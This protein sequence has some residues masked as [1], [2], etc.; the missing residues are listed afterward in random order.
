M[1]QSLLRAFLFS[2]AGKFLLP[3]LKQLLCASKPTIVFSEI[4]FL[5][6]GIKLKGAFTLMN[7][8]TIHVHH[9]VNVGITFT[10]QFG[11]PAEVDGAPQ[12]ASSDPELLTV[13]P[14]EDGKS[15]LFTAGTRVGQVQ[16]SCTADALPG[17]EVENFALTASITLVGGKASAGSFSVG[18]EE[19]VVDQPADGGAGGTPTI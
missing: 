4:H 12:W 18:A 13:T 2:W 8:M 15:C 17:D 14:S 3:A 11:N 10:D 16:V 9:K 1:L 7:E 6:E 5:E 19:E